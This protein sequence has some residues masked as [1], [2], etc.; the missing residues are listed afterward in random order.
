MGEFKHISVLL[1][2]CIEN[3]K[4]MEFFEKGAHK[5]T[6]NV[7]TNLD[8]HN[9]VQIVKVYNNEKKEKVCNIVGW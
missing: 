2:E 4:N 7:N 8:D 1:N 6:L 5:F 3:L 9:T